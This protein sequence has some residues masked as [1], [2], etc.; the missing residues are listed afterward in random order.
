VGDGDNDKPVPAGR[1]FP[2]PDD[3]FALSLGTVASPAESRAIARVAERYFAAARA[4]DAAKVCSM[5]IPALAASV[6]SSG[7][8]RRPGET[9]QTV[10][11]ALF[12]RHRRELAAAIKVVDVRI[13]YAVRAEVV[14]GSKTMPASLTFLRRRGSAWMID[15]VLGMPVG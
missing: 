3:A 4:G 5:M 13:E 2:D 6:T 7:P 15:Q 1:R 8:T 14:F 9:C 10:M 12:R 11:S